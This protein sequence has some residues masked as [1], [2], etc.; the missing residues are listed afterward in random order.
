VT[1]LG[2]LLLVDDAGAA[3]ADASRITTLRPDVVK[4]DRGLFW[5][6]DEDGAAREM[7]GELLVAARDAGARLLVE[8]ISDAEQVER[9][10]GIG[11]DLAQGFHL[12]VP[13]APDRMPELLAD[14]HRRI[15]VDAPGL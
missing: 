5:K 6:I 10:R 2:G 14:L 11:A 4:I 15:G 7:L 8:G 13:T 1:R 12:G 3:C 9:A